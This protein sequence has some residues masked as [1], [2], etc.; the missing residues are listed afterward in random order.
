MTILSRLFLRDLPNVM[1]LLI[2]TSIAAHADPAPITPRTQM[3][4]V[5]DIDGYVDDDDVT[6][7]SRFLQQAG[8]KHIP[9]PD[10]LATWIIKRMSELGP[11]AS[12]RFLQADMHFLRNGSHTLP[13]A[14]GLPTSPRYRI[15]TAIL[16]DLES[17]RTPI[18]DLGILMFQEI[19]DAAL[20]NAA[21]SYPMSSL[22]THPWMLQGVWEDWM[23]WIEVGISPDTSGLTAATPQ[24]KAGLL[25]HVQAYLS[26]LNFS[27]PT[28]NSSILFPMSFDSGVGS[29]GHLAATAIAPPQ[30]QAELAQLTDIATSTSPRIAKTLGTTVPQGYYQPYG[31]PRIVDPNQF[32]QLIAGTYLLALN[33]PMSKPNDV[34]S[35]PQDHLA[36]VLS[37]QQARLFAL[38]AYAVMLERRDRNDISI[39]LSLGGVITQ[40]QAAGAATAQLHAVKQRSRVKVNVSAKNVTAIVPTITNDMLSNTLTSDLSPLVSCSP[41]SMKPSQRYVSLKEQRYVESGS[42]ICSNSAK[43]NYNVNGHVPLII[44][45]ALELNTRYLDLAHVSL[46][47][48]ELTTTISPDPIDLIQRAPWQSAALLL[49]MIAHRDTTW[50]EVRDSLLQNL[51]NSIQWLNPGSQSDFRDGSSYRM[52]LDANNLPTGNSVWPQSRFAKIQSEWLLGETNWVQYNAD[53]AY[54]NELGPFV[55]AMDPTQSVPVNVPCQNQNGSSGSCSGTTLE[56]TARGVYIAQLNQIKANAQRAHANVDELSTDQCRNA[57]LGNQTVGTIRTIIDDSFQHFVSQYS[58]GGFCYGAVQGPLDATLSS[59]LQQILPRDPFSLR[60]IIST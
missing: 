48:R 29:W 4:I 49:G 21:K 26:Q 33:V 7:I 19:D 38:A 50:P 18:C 12:P 52:I 2:C 43:I 53:L 25:A 11:G 56:N 40:L 20:N 35:G 14:A 39:D 17:E 47:Q 5:A 3:L 22:K 8:D 1:F 24:A 32:V 10:D 36:Y 58:D 37:Q 27:P 46:S 9:V 28:T 41:T 60:D 51:P 34:G 15:L 44:V 6:A 57:N 30:E 23:Y 42:A 13:F 16:K 45:R 55:N 59:A 54:A 31:L